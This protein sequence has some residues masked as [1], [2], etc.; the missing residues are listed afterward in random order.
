[1]FGYRADNMPP[2]DSNSKLNAANES[3]L[4]TKPGNFY[5]T[6]RC[7]SIAFDNKLGGTEM[8]VTYEQSSTCSELG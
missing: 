2:E 6:L 4:F 5:P 3:P 8:R 1:M 7:S